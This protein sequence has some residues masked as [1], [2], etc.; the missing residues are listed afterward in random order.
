MEQLR[1]PGCMQLKTSRPVCERCGFDETKANAPHQLPLGT[2]LRDQYVVGRVLGQGGFGITY[3]GWDQHMG[4][5]VAIKEYYPNHL[6]TRD[7]S[8]SLEV[9]GLENNHRQSFY[10][11]R[12]RFL[13]EAQALARFT[14]VPEIV[15]V[16]TC[17]EAH[18]T[19]Y[20]IME[21]LQGVDLRGFVRGHGGRLTPEMTLEVLKPV[22]HALSIVHKAGLVHRDISPDNI[23]MLS[24]TQA[25]LL[26]FG[27]VREV[28]DDADAERELSK[29]TESILKHGFAPMEQYQKRGSL[30]PWTDVYALCATIY[31][32]L[33]GRIPPDAP[34]RMLEDT[35]PQWDRIP[36][37]TPHQVAVLEKGMAMRA[38][39]R[40]PSV[41]ALY[42][43]LFGGARLPEE[44]PQ[45][46]P[47]T[48]PLDRGDGENTQPAKENRP[49]NTPPVS[50]ERPTKPRTR[51][52]TVSLGILAVLCLIA[53]AFFYF[54]RSFD[55]PTPSLS[56]PVQTQPETT[57]PTALPTQA[58]IAPTEA[59]T[60]PTTLPPETLPPVTQPEETIPTFPKAEPT[61]N[62][63]PNTWVRNVMIG[64]YDPG[65]SS[66]YGTYSVFGSAYHRN[67]I[68]SITFLDNVADAPNT[69]W[70]A[71]KAQNRSVLAW[72]EPNGA[73]FDLYIGAPGGIN[74]SA[75]CAYLFAGFRNARTI[76]FGVSF[77]MTGAS[78]LS[79]MFYQCESLE[80]LD[81]SGF[82][83][84]TVMYMDSVF[85]GCNSLKYLDVSGFNT[86][87]VTNFS[88]MFSGCHSLKTLD[89]SGFDISQSIDTSMMFSGC[90]NVK[91]L[92]VSGFDTSRVANFSAMFNGCTSV[93][94][95]DVGG[96]RTP[97]ATNMAWMFSGCASVEVLDVGQFKTV[98]VLDM[99]GVFS[100]C[101]SLK[102]LDV[103][104]FITRN[105]LGMA[106]MFSDCSSLTKLNVK[107]LAG[108]MST[109]LRGMFSGCSSL[110]Y[111]DISTIR[112]ESCTDMAYM[113][114]GCSSLK[115]LDVSQLLTSY[116]VTMEGMFENCSSLEVLDVTTFL[117]YNVYSMSRMF[118]GCN[119]QII[120]NFN[121]FNTRKV[122]E[123][124]NFMN[125]KAIVNGK[126]W[127]ELFRK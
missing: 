113:F 72:V 91:V 4:R 53:G 5:P 65:T 120:F 18:N 29:S 66:D 45:D 88:A 62:Y 78:S 49:A 58:T 73:L 97:C 17:F 76:D 109:T 39:D 46:L 86:E 118:Y 115:E 89:V 60:I 50:P 80:Y 75:N 63:A 30:G 125:D 26:D 14:Q 43:L 79:H 112:T 96:F 64:S 110:E 126:Y 117:T 54:F 48:L 8:H 84:S 15:R 87:K 103:S 6:V 25:K 105:A 35:H 13:R 61:W 23:M 67:Q 123:F 19:A 24:R 70:D 98:S 127:E 69:A 99:N 71:S 51:S 42:A 31:Y 11:G 36:G 104:H 38:R 59:P 68:A 116:V 93:K 7:T 2:V 81:V 16:Y 82:D 21:Y 34:A 83:T 33:T 101:S 106:Y 119:A 10:T 47:P 1:C 41:D 108:G 56:H 32:C 85:D 57:A 22:I 114:A 92:D 107:G 94:E 52:L 9:T 40:I 122:M 55:I 74:A 20:I 100:G 111:L 124:E 28:G 77:H 3:L 121:N 37:L 12:D 44:E 95:L 102:T 27:A 90:S